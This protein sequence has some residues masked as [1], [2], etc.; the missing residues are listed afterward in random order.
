MDQMRD[1]SAYW[2]DP[3]RGGQSLGGLANWSNNSFSGGGIH[4]YNIASNVPINTSS[5]LSLTGDETSLFV[6]NIYSSTSGGTVPVQ[7]KNSI[8]LN[9]IGPDQVFFNILGQATGSANYVLSASAGQLRGTMYVAADSYSINTTIVSGRLMGGTGTSSWGA[10]FVA[11]APVDVWSGTPEPSG[12]VLMGT[13]LAVLGWAARR[14]LVRTD[15]G[16]GSG[17]AKM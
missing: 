4:V 7:W 2:A 13:G 8:Q 11:N 15:A 16:G 6:F 3:A 10:N 5:A 9:G 14:A 1:I 12:Y 17:A